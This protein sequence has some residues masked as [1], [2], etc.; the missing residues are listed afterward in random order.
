MQGIAFHRAKPVL[1]RIVGIATAMGISVSFLTA[2]GSQEPGDAFPSVVGAADGAEISSPV[3]CEPALSIEASGEKS[4]EADTAQRREI[5]AELWE[6]PQA[7][8][9]ADMI[10]EYVVL[11]D[12]TE[13][14][15]CE[16]VNGAKT[17]LRVR[18][19]YRE[20]PPD[21]YR[22]REDWFFFLEG[23]D[24]Q[25]LY[26]DY[27]DKDWENVEKDRYVWDACDFEAHLEDVTFDGREDLVISLGQSGNRGDYIYGVYVYEDGFYQYKP[28]FEEIPNYETDEDEQVIRGWSLDGPCSA[29]TYI[30]KYED[31]DF[32][33]IACEW[34]DDI[35]SADT[36][37]W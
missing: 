33:Q 16:W 22:H 36:L 7:I 20:Y 8:Q 29:A 28:G 5:P 13:I 11:S 1:C 3:S 25:A 31:G 34:Y 15:A 14:E 6:D 18:V 23:E 30:Y 21:N 17:C 9:L 24:I 37:P 19:Q 10:D 12:D 27:P 26:V 32:E 4:Q 2:C 35:F